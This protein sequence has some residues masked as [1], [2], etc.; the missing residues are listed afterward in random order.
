MQGFSGQIKRKCNLLVSKI[1]VK[2][3][4]SLSPNQK[5]FLKRFLSPSFENALKKFSSNEVSNAYNKILDLRI[6]LYTLGFIDRVLM[7]L[8]KLSLESANPYLKSLAAWELSLWYAN[9]KDFRKCLDNLIKLKSNKKYFNAVNPVPILEAECYRA[10][11]DLA[12]ARDVLFKAMKES[13]NNMN[14]YI[15]MANNENSV[16][17]RLKWI[18]KIYKHESLSIS[19]RD[20][21]KSLI[22]DFTTIDYSKYKLSEPK[23]SVIVPLFDHINENHFNRS[24]YSLLNQ[25]WKNIEVLIVNYNENPVD[26]FL[27]DN[28]FVRNLNK[29]SIIEALYLASGDYV[30]F[31]HPYEY[32]HPKRFECQVLH[33]LKQKNL[34]GVMVQQASCSLEFIFDRINWT[35]NYITDDLKTLMF[36]SQIISQ[37]EIADSNDFVDIIEQVEEQIGKKAISKLNIGPL[38]FRHSSYEFDNRMIAN[39]E[40]DLSSKNTPKIVLNNVKKMQ[41]LEQKNQKGQMKKHFDVVLVS[42]FRLLG[43]S[44]QS[45]IEEIKAQKWLGMKTGLLQLCRYDFDPKREVIQ[46]VQDLVDND[47]VEMIDYWDNVSCDVLILRYPPVLQEK[48]YIV[49]K[50]LT[51][52]VHVIINQPPMSD[53]GPD[54]VMRYNLRRSQK[55]LQ[56]YFGCKGIWHPIGPLVREAL[57]K[58]HSEDLPAIDLSDENWVNIINIHEWKT[59]SVPKRNSKPRIGRHSRDHKVKWPSDPEELLKIYPD[60]ESYD[61]YILGG[62]ETPRELLGYIPKNWT[63]YEFNQIHPKDF[64]RKIDVFVYFTNPNWVESFGRVIIEAMASG[65]P[66]ILPHSYESLFKGGAIFAEPEQVKTEIDKLMQDS[67]Y[68]ER[69]ANKGLEFVREHFSYEKHALR[70]KQYH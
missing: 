65:V 36:N 63:V 47:A 52:N 4:E 14:C 34:K 12:K 54:S 70:L 41:F 35:S 57:H 39:S 8:E 10:M 40:F 43:G 29:H 56:E 6:K 64:L 23:V 5:Q 55:H 44:N 66:V 69:Q 68:Y 59:D 42:D 11:G 61:V 21:E 45:N 1:M 13:T 25:T 48:Q 24:I 33:L 18:N 17:E 67:A 60:D 37:M 53:Y 19:L 16:E 62:V 58:Y 2:F 26:R 15:A 38:A 9:R 50:I 46:E 3:K 28:R 27:I 32:S 30:V 49:P 51:N 31:H 22:C 20:L 7:D